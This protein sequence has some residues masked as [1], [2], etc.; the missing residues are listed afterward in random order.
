LLHSKAT[1]LESLAV[2]WLGGSIVG[3]LPLNPLR[4]FHY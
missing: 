2:Q 3:C 1:R 4:V